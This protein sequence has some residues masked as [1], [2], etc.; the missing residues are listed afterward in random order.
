ME[1]KYR[2]L[3]MWI[4]KEI[5][6]IMVVQMTHREKTEAMRSIVSGVLMALDR[7]DNGHDM[8]NGEIPF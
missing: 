7:I 6:F 8:N 1:Y 3:I 2:R 5:T 4:V